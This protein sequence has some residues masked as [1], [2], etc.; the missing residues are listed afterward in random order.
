MVYSFFYGELDELKSYKP[1]VSEDTVLVN[2]YNFN[3]DTYFN[4]SPFDKDVKGGFIKFLEYC[5]E[6]NIRVRLYNISEEIF[7]KYFKRFGDI[8]II[9]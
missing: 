9:R 1:F 2:M 4:I 8:Q 5:K 6:Y 7:D 3:P